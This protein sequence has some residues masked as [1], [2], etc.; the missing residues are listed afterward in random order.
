[1]FYINYYSTPVESLVLPWSH[2]STFNALLDFLIR[3][4]IVMVQLSFSNYAFSMNTEG[5]VLLV[6]SETN[7]VCQILGGFSHRLELA[8]D[9]QL[10][11]LASK[12]LELDIPIINDLV[13]MT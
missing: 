10:G 2:N 8:L 12:L 3:A 5:W 9:G 11:I 13:G 4:N 6:S 1:M 7:A